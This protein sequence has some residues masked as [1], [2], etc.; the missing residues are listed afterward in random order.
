MRGRVG[1]PWGRQQQQYNNNF[2]FVAFCTLAQK[3]LAIYQGRR[4]GEPGLLR[5]TDLGRGKEKQ[6]D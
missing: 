4:V 1:S 5:I 6:M 2:D 3:L